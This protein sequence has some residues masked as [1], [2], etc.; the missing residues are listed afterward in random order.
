MKKTFSWLALLALTATLFVGCNN[1]PASPLPYSTPEPTGTTTLTEAPTGITASDATQAPT[2]DVTQAATLSPVPDATQAATPSPVPDATQAATP[3]PVPDAT[4]AATPSP[5]PD[6]TQAATPTPTLGVT[7]AATPTPT[8]GVTPAATPTP[9][10]T[11]LPTVAP[12]NTS[13][14]TYD[15]HDMTYLASYGTSYTV[16]SDGSIFLQYESIYQEIK[17]SIPEGINMKYCKRVTLKA[18]SSYAPISFKLY[19]ENVLSDPYCGEIAVKY[20]C[21]GDGIVEYELLPELDTTVSG[22]GIMANGT[23]DTYSYNNYTATVYSITFYLEE[24]YTAAPTPT[25][26]IPASTNGATLLNTY[27]TAFGSIGTCINLSQLQTASTL[28]QVK[29]QY[30]SVTLENEMKPDALLGSSPTLLPVDYAKSL[31]YIIPDNYTEKN[32]PQINFTSVDRALELCAK[33]GLRMRAHTLVW[34]SQTPNWFFRTSYSSSG[35]FVRETVMDAR[36]EFYIRNVMAHI[37][38][39]EYG[40][41]VYSWDIVNEYLHA[42]DT[43]WLAIYGK[44]GLRPGFVKKAYEIADEVLRAYGVRDK[45]SLLFN[46]YNTYMEA[47]EL[48]SIVAYINSDRK[49]CDGIGMQAH[50]DTGYPSPSLFRNTLQAF[51]DAGLEVQITELDVTNTSV[52]EQA[53]YLYEL[54]RNVLELK[55]NGGKITG[56]TYW[57]IADDVSWRG[58][59][60]PLLFSTLTSPKKS[61]YQVLQAYVDAGFQ[62]K[63]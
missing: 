2:P 57:G 48:L 18:N 61:Y 59:Q 25:P 21:M 52:S 1:A 17:L 13:T 30:N 29:A 39:G 4:Q 51:L 19:G 6:A 34:H 32:V 43:N 23:A 45:V 22:I 55:K 26:F 10:V 60:S 24:N 46:D 8:L 7:P 35:G 41:V 12:A 47:D 16:Q 58:F 38:G 53:A 31:G 37:Y 20:D 44:E 54:M 49:I 11:Q 50:L 36:M 28:A 40:N 3:T 42:D 9:S 56:I 27:G 62:I 5:V 14:V 33:N 63:K 15:F